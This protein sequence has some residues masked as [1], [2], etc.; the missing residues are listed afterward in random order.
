MKSKNA[1]VVVLLNI[2][3]SLAT[4]GLARP[5]RV[6][7]LNCLSCHKGIE[8]AG[9]RHSFRCT[10][11]HLPDFFG[12]KLDSHKPIIRNPADPKWQLTVCIRCHRK[13]VENVNKSL[14]GTLAGVI[15]QTRYLWGAQSHARPPLYSAN[16][17]IKQLPD[18]PPHPES[19]S[20]LVDDFL[21]RKC[22]QCHLSVP[23]ANVK[24]LYR[25]TGC[26]ACHSL[27][28]NDG[29]Y[30]G[31]DA[32]IDKSKKGYPVKHGLTREIPTTQCLHCH[33]SNHVG[34]DYLGLFQSDFNI[35]YQEVIA[36]GSQPAYR[37]SY[38]QL[39]PDVH[40]RLG[41]R[42]TDCHEK[43]EIMGDGTTPGLIPDAIKTSCTKCHP[44]FSDPKFAMSG[45]SHR[46]KEHRRLRCSACHAAWSFQDYGLSVMLTLE[47]SYKKWKHLAYQ[48][49]PFL[50]GLFRKELLKPFPDLPYCPDLLTGE[51]KPGMWILAWRFRRWE[52]MPLGVDSKGRI[53]IMRPRYQYIV[54][55]ADRS[56][57]T[58]LDGVLPQR[59]D[60][61]GIGWAFNPYSPH[62]ISPAGRSCH[63]CHGNR[64][65]A[66]YGFFAAP[67]F[68]TF[69]SVPSPPVDP[70]S[71]LFTKEEKEKLLRLSRKYRR[72][73]HE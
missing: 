25:A 3:L 17:A 21:R 15:N 51:N 53:T 63:S 47:P 12:Q 22:L 49:D 65:A 67:A 54:S 34:S 66:G 45:L 2:L 72:Y 18:D 44:G 73:I 4:S 8:S 1:V 26:A 41:L 36:T 46:I 42:C 48:G 28:N 13:E 59:G 37:T 68:D 58:F 5:E 27:Y 52:Y 7:F 40:F 57:T 32:A 43:E 31:N 14:H 61:T 35:T 69:L 19:S 56:G 62:T 30:R 60:A 11:C 55:Y 29:L 6:N 64:I 23:G 16:K 9:K 70:R 33:N 38:I 20:G 71:R 24:G 50:L 39:S 10:K